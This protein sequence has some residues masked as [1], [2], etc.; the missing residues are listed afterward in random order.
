MINVFYHN[1]HFLSTVKCSIIVELKCELDERLSRNVS[2]NRLNKK[3]SKRNTQWSKNDILNQV[4]TRRIIANED[5][6][7]R[8]NADRF[9]SI[10]NTN[11]DA[12]DVAK[13]IVSNLD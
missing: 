7:K 12:K 9:I 8:F 2:D 4:L 1:S 10:D 6:I 3:P 11:L 13:L 5:D